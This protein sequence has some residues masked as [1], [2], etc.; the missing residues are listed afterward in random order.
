VKLL[1]IG[2]GSI[3]RKHAANARAAGHEV[4]LLRH[5]KEN[6]NQDGLREYYSLEEAVAN[7]KTD[8]A[9]ICS[10]TSRHLPDV[11]LLVEHRIPFL[12]E[13]PPAAEMESTLQMEKL[14]LQSGFG[15]YAI[16]FN[17]RYYP[18]LLFIKDFL[19]QLGKVYSARIAAG[20]Y[21]PNWRRDVDYRETS[22]AKK[23]LGGGV[24]IELVHE[25][26]YLVW[27][28][29]CPEKVSGYINHVSDLEI[30]TADICAAL[31]RY[32][33]DSVVEL[34]LDYLSH[35]YLRGC[36]IVAENGTLE[37]EMNGGS[38]YHTERAGRASEEVF[39]PSPDY[40]FN[41]TYVE[42]LKDF[43]GIIQGRTESRV[44]MSDCV[45]TMRVLEAI[46]LSSEKEEWVSLGDI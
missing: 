26:D 8:G 30:S 40:D 43:I 10:P 27:F 4:A 38:V 15:E 20:Y 22:S 7:G 13:K 33:D 45:K 23:E 14:L 31:L 19:P 2:Y 46:R 37:W 5:S 44:E 41:E 9:I 18:A 25:I 6:P 39:S 12:L 36:Q 16:G 21:L 1:V 3:G 32:R 29:G 34:H 11:E 42:E 24:H 35:R 28:F 17:L